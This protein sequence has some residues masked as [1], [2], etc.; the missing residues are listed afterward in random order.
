[1]LK[2]ALDKMLL[3]CY[4][5]GEGQ[6]QGG[7][8]N[9][10]KNTCTFVDNAIAD[11]IKENGVFVVLKNGISGMAVFPKSLEDKCSGMIPSRG[12]YIFHFSEVQNSC[13]LNG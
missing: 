6:S 13:I 11:D 5:M 12:F 1:M 9:Q 3:V 7:I 8:M 10:I 2:I 4:Y